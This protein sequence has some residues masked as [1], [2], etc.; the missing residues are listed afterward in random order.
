MIVRTSPFPLQP[1]LVV[2]QSISPDLTRATA[3]AYYSYRIVKPL[4]LTAGV[5]FDHLEYPQNDELPPLTNSESY[6]NQFSP[7]L[8]FRWTPFEN[9]AIRGVWTRSLGGVFYDTSVRLEPTEIAGFNQAFR[10]LIPESVAGL[11]PGSRFDTYGLAFDQN[12]PTRTYLTI[13]AEILRSRGDRTIGVL[14]ALGPFNTRASGVDETLDFQES[15]ASVVVNQLSEE[16]AVG[17]SYRCGW[18]GRSDRPA[19]PCAL[20]ANFARA[21]TARSTRY[22]SRRTCMRWSTF[23]AA[24]TARR[25]LSGRRSRTT[26]I[27]RCRKAMILRSTRLPATGCGASRSSKSAW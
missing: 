10:S 7:K 13:D 16:L 15:S 19:G 12:F 2:G 23:H 26:I 17:G 20:S 22:C 9:T 11:V 4:L 24:F 5:A 6:K 18:P 25:R 8:G 27:R 21:R 3:Y 1:P 14:E